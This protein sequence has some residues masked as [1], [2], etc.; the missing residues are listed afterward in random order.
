[1]NKTT[2]LAGL[3]LVLSG[4]APA[5]AEETETRIEVGGISCAACPYIVRSALEQVP[6]VA[7]TAITY[8]GDTTV[9]VELRYDDETVTVEDLLAATGNVGFPSR[10]AG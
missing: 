9:L 4:L 5:L 7:V 2:I 8:V 10:P 3:S 6:G 1:M